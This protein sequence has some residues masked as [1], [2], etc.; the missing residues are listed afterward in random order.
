VAVR[1]SYLLEMVAAGYFARPVVLLSPTFSAQDEEADF[2]R[3]ARLSRV[4]V[5][6]RLPWSVFPRIIDSS[7]KGA[8]CPPTA[9]TSSLPR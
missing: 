9:A 1:P 7:F 2:R 8:G 4:P 5:V 6:G 3:I